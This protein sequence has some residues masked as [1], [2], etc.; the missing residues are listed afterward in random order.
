MC[1]LV[2]LFVC[3]FVCLSLCVCVSGV[4]ERM[5][6]RNQRCCRGRQALHGPCCDAMKSVEYKYIR[7]YGWVRVRLGRSVGFCLAWL[8]VWGR[9]LGFRASFERLK[10]IALPKMRSIHFSKQSAVDPLHFVR[11]GPGLTVNLASLRLSPGA[12]KFAGCCQDTLVYIF[13]KPWRA[14]QRCTGRLH[15]TSAMLPRPRLIADG[16][17]RS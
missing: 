15:R 5:P 12:G 17:C 8:K 10:Y 13:H 1:V 11:W 2:C 16:K 4:W 14:T 3:L 6:Q 7:C 9:A